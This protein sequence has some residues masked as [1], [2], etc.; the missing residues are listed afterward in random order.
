MNDFEAFL[1]VIVVQ[2]LYKAALQLYKKVNVATLDVDQHTHWAAMFV[3][4]GYYMKY[5]GKH[6]LFNLFVWKTIPV[7]TPQISLLSILSY[8]FVSEFMTDRM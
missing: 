6:L 5:Q 3:P 4:R 2:D 8:E 7:S 1:F